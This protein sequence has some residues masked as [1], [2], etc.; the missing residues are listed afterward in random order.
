[1]TGTGA[2]DRLVEKLVPLVTPSGLL[3]RRAVF[4]FIPRRQN[5]LYLLI[6]RHRTPRRESVP[7]APPSCPHIARA[8]YRR[9]LP[10][11]PPR[12]PMLSPLALLHHARAKEQLALRPARGALPEGACAPAEPVPS[13]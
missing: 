7:G 10:V 1:M 6:T 13:V 2:D 3:G 4:Q 11:S 12:P 5:R 8:A 9:V